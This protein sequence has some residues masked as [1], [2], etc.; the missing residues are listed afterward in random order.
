MSGIATSPR[1]RRR[2][3]AIGLAVG[4]GLLLLA[5]SNWHLVHV[6]ISSQPDCVPHLR[7]GEGEGRPGRLQ[8]RPLRLPVEVT[9]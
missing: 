1:A 7:Q 5:G 4:A 3:L 6:A 8:R 2:K 9:E